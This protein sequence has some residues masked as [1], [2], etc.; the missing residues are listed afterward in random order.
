MNTLMTPPLAP[1]LAQI[2]A[3]ADVTQA[4]LEQQL[5]IFPLKNATH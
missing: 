3:E 5:R 4:T 1:L 2:F